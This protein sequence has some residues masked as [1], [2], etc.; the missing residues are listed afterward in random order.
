MSMPVPMSC[1]RAREYHK[2]MTIE[3]SDSTVSALN[4]DDLSD[5]SEPSLS[6]VAFYMEFEGLDLATEQRPEGKMPSEIAKDMITLQSLT[7]TVG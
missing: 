7:A 2:H 1:H 6:E 3:R 5:A 4:M